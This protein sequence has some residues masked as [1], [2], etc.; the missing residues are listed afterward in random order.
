MYFYDNFTKPLELKGITGRLIVRDD[1]SNTDVAAVDMRP[2]RDGKT[3]DAPLK[4]GALPVRVQARIRFNKATEEQLFDFRFTEYSK[5]VPAPVTTTRLAPK[6]AAPAAKPSA[7]AATPPAAAPTPAPAAPAAA[8]VAP[9]PAPT[10]SVPPASAPPPPATV[11]PAD[12]PPPA[13]PADAATAQTPTATGQPA[14]GGL[15]LMPSQIQQEEMLPQTA[16]ELLALLE[17]RGREAETLI[18]DGLF[19]QVYVPAMSGKNIALALENFVGA[20]PNRQRMQ[21][22]EAL[23]RAVVAAWKLDMAGDIGNREDLLGAYGQFAAAVSDIQAAYGT[24]R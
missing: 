15:D 14:A 21:A 9:A 12:A 24:A 8:A 13:A 16:P 20:L 10:A 1:A 23:R 22:S 19:A 17:Q 5:D 6:P 18:K 7:P 3:L 2:S 11:A 4:T